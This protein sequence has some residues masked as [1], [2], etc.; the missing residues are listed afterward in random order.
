MIRLLTAAD[1][2]L[3]MAL[4]Q[5]QPAEN[6][7]IIGDI[8]AF[9]Y[10]QPFQK[11]WGQ[12]EGE[13]L[14]AVL[15]KYDGNYIPYA[16]GPFNADGFEAIFNSDDNAKELSGLK[17]LIDQI[18]PKITKNSTRK[19]ELFYAKCTALSPL[20]PATELTDVTRLT[21]NEFEEN[22]ALIHAIPEF[23]GSP[24]T[25][26]S[27]LRAEENKTGRTYIM[28]E[29]N[30]MV[31]TASTTAENSM[32]AMIV[33][34]ATREGYKKKGYASKCMQKICG[35][36]LNEGKSLCLFYDNPVAGAIYKRLGFEDIGMWNMIRY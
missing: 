16:Q 15:L 12:F 9:G 22:I 35:D 26:E 23:A 29:D 33:G 1:H 3:C 18:G 14:I 32:S 21:I 7:F 24:T 34:V 17:H 31:C 2:E 19:N 36:L 25:V 10:D 4:V 27:K 30:V 28:R 11:V 8:E 5:Q 13:K 6:L 20:Y